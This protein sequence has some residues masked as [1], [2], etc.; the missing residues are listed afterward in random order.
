MMPAFGQTGER[1]KAD[2]PFPFMVGDKT[3]EAGTYDIREIHQ[4]VFVI[5]EEAPEGEGVLAVTNGANPNADAKTPTLTFSHC[6][7]TY[8]LAQIHTDYANG[9][10]PPTK[11][12]RQLMAATKDEDEVVVAGEQ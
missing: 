6:G 10:L 8:F 5:R 12:E 3:L 9:A 1:I 4:G 2:I 11:K 7:N